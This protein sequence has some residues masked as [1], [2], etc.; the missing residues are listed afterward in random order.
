M[1]LFFVLAVS[2]MMVYLITPSIRYMAL[3]A[4]AI[5]KKNH[6]KIHRKIIAQLGG[7]AIYCGMWGG[8]SIVALLDPLFFKTN[9]L[10]IMGFGICSTLM[11]LLGVYDDFQGSGATMKFIVQIVIALLFV[12]IGF[13]LE[14]ITFFNLIDIRLGLLST[15]VTVLWLVGVTNAINLIDGLDGLATGIVAIASVFFCVY[16]VL[17]QEKFVIFTALALLGASLAFLRYNFHPAKIFLGD[18]GSLFLGFVMGSLAIW[19]SKS[20]LNYPFF[21]PAVVVLLIPITDT[22]LAIL[23]RLARGQHLFRGDASHL[24]HYYIK[25]GLSQT[26]VVTGF[27]VATFILGLTSIL[28]FHGYKF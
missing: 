15:P 10:L 8:L 26:Q 16:G 7:L 20:S 9:I 13:K 23:R 17:F 19:N 27:Y 11:L 24:H 14:R 1:T 2:F 12:R 28:F 6:R 4:S 22:I 21:F 5:D 25:R 18:T 3:K